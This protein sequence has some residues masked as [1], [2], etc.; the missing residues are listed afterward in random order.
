MTEIT[1]SQ[2]VISFWLFVGLCFLVFCIGIF[3]VIMAWYQLKRDDI[4]VVSSQVDRD[5]IKNL[6]KLS[7]KQRDQVGRELSIRVDDD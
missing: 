7:E 5:I 1:N 6:L 3:L 4:M 2:D